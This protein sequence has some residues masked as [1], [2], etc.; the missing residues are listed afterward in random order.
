MGTTPF[1]GGLGIFD[2]M[3]V[4][5][6]FLVALFQPFGRRH[7]HEFVQ[8]FE[9]VRLQ[10]GGGDRV[11][12]V[13]AAQRFGNDFV[14]EAEFQQV[15]GGD[16]EGFGGLGRGGAVLPENGGATFRADDR[17]IG[18]F[19]NQ[20]PVGHA[21]AQRA[22]RTAFADDGGDDGHFEQGHLA[23]IDGDGLGDVAFFRA[24]AGIGAG[25]VNEGDDG[26]AEFVG[27]PHQAQR[28]AIAFGVGGAEIAQ[29]VFLG[30]PAFLGA[31]H[32]HAMFA[33]PGKTADHG[34]VFGKK[35]VAVQ[36]LEIRESLLQVIQ[37]VG[38]DGTLTTLQPRPSPDAGESP[39][40]DCRTRF[41][42]RSIIKTPRAC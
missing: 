32:Q 30:V 18:V 36:F 19:Q 42:T 9:Q 26:Q 40:W 12:V 35:P 8:V 15:F 2:E 11:V 10:I 27:Q 21:D 14:H 38:K 7:G 31:D 6:E 28:L 23:E 5:A 25:R 29:D 16:F 37:R 13:R 1:H 39:G 4:G 41:S 3:A 22:A 34:A 17:V 33:Q 24:D 20:H